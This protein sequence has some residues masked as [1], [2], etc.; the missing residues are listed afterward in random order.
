MA[1]APPLSVLFPVRNGQETVGEAL[2]SILH[3]SFSNFE[4]LVVDDG[5]TDDTGE[6]LRQAAREDDRVR[7]I[8]QERAGIVPALEAARAKARGAF[9]ARMD[10][11]DISLPGRFQKQMDL[12][13]SDR[14]IAACGTGILYVP[15][16][17]VREG[18][19]R[20]E[21]WINGL[22][23][24]ESIEQDL[25]V[26]C[27]IPH[28][29]FFLRASALE[30][31]GGYRDRGWP[32]DYDLVLRLW[33]AGGRF[34]K[35]PETHLHWREGPARLSRT[36]AAYSEDSFRR[37]KVSF[38]LRTHL[39]RGRDV[40]VWGAGPV[41]KAFA[42][43]LQRQ[44]GTL[45]AFVDLDPRKIGQTIYGVPVVSSAGVH[46]FPQAFHVA[47]VAKGRGRDEIRGSLTE[48]GK[49]EIRDFVAVA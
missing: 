11:D 15:R 14:R 41:G 40:V 38:L 44:G 9:L 31:V 27:P 25:F 1:A 32:E 49:V 23:N 22:A 46:Q 28:P 7:L 43:E 34:Q 13:A 24:H 33:E 12:M 45:V 42:K 36:H 26:E 37:C 21:R 48:A 18:S 20:Y 3:Q 30:S 10:A 19:L 47:A 39:S 16:E 17:S 2:D 35:V 6:I 8:S 4:L 5:S 29:T